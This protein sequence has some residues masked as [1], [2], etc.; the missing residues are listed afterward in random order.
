[1]KRGHS[2]GRVGLQARTRARD[3]HRRVTRCDI[4]GRRQ[5]RVSGNRR[6]TW[7][8]R[9][10]FDVN[11]TPHPTRECRPPPRGRWQLSTR[12]VKFSEP[13]SGWQVPMLPTWRVQKGDANF[14]G[15]YGSG[16]R[17]DSDSV[18][19]SL[20]SVSNESP[21]KWHGKGENRRL[22]SQKKVNVTLYCNVSSY[23]KNGR[24]NPLVKWKRWTTEGYQSGSPFVL[25]CQMR[26]DLF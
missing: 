10:P 9:S 14:P 2:W 11:S 17:D 12:R 22:V 6:H 8:Q 20:G 23:C 1:M 26:S 21:P 13:M 15:S 19:L 16:P 3:E 24:G 18:V 7:R 5:R 25:L 4:Y